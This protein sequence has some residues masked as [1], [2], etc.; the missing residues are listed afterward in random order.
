MANRT[1]T[2]NTV[3]PDLG[4]PVLYVDEYKIHTGNHIFRATFPTTEE[5]PTGVYLNLTS[6]LA[7]GYSVWLNLDYIGSH[8]GRSYLGAY[9]AEFSLDNATLSAEQGR[10]NILV[11]MMDN[12]GHDLRE[13]ALASRGITNATL[14]G[15][16]AEAGKGYT[17][18]EWKIAG[19]AGGGQGYIDPIRGPLNEGG[20][21]AERL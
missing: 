16:A 1:N 13:V 21:Y 15:P 4:N 19:K 2:T 20:L 8:L 5:P 10:E 18:T 17:F 3:I 11:V 9:G 14:W 12:S 6:G 7:F